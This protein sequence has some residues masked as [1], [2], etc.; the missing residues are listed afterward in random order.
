MRQKF[1]VIKIY[2]SDTLVK[3][4]NPAS[5]QMAMAALELFSNVGNRLEIEVCEFKPE[6]SP[7]A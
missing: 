3:E 6:R 7:E 5:P 4:V 1:L 2:E